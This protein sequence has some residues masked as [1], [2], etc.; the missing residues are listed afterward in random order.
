MAAAKGEIADDSTIAGLVTVLESCLD[1]KPGEENL[2]VF[3]ADL[4]AKVTPELSWIDSTRK[5]A[6]QLKK[7]G[8]YSRTSPNG[9]AKGYRI[10]REW[11]KE[12]RARYLPDTSAIYPSYSQGPNDNNSLELFSMRRTAGQT[13]DRKT[14]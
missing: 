3:S 2:F 11:V 12:L 7:F 5:L 9:K 8:A 4:L 6:G 10:S 13:T 1:E 14:T